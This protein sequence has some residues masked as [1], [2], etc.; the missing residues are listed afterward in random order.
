MK[1]EPKTK[2]N[3]NKIKNE[4]TSIYTKKPSQKK[5]KNALKDAEKAEK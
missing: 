2:Y 1:N 3:P 4:K 5:K